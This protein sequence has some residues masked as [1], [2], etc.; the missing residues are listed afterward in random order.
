MNSTSGTPYGARPAPDSDPRD[1]ITE[2]SFAIAPELLGMP[3]AGPWRRLGGILVD[4]ALAGLLSRA[5]GYLFA[6]GAAVLLWRAVAS[7]EA[8]VLRTSRR[9]WVRAVALGIVAIVLINLM[10]HAGDVVSRIGSSGSDDAEPADVPGV[11]TLPGLSGIG[12]V[13]DVMRLRRAESPEEANRIAAQLAQKAREMDPDKRAELADAV[14]EIPDADL[15]QAGLDTFSVR[16]LRESF[17]PM[18][19]AAE[20]VP[21]ASIDSLGV[22][23]G[24]AVSAGDSVRAQDVLARLSAAAAAD[25][26]GRVSR[27]LA[28]ARSENR[29]LR[30]EIEAQKNKGFFASIRD[31]ADDLGMGVG[32]LGLYFTAFTWW[33][34]GRTPGKRLF[35]MQVLR[36]DGKPMTLWASF[37]RF[38]GYAAGLATGLLGFAQIFWD[39]NRQAAHDKISETVV[40]RT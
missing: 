12:A 38:G 9:F 6:I 40:V 29:Q 16:A 37:E 28:S 39:R 35:G 27:R 18:A 1:T 3:L 30:Q 10:Q 8:G 33:W 36:L 5:G 4:L 7:S 14:M 21:R 11:V 31:W 34:S 20:P 17:R 32:W 24:E 15:A 23:Y 26:V 2:E 22:A 19:A 25:S 13:A